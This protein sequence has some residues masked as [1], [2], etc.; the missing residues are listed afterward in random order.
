M[1]G[2]ARAVGAGTLIDWEGT[3]YVFDGLTLEDYGILK[4]HLVEKKRKDKIGFIL[5]LAGTL[6]SDVHREHLDRA[7]VEAGQIADVEDEE[8]DKWVHTPDGAATAMWLSLSKRYGI[9]KAP[10][11]ERILRKLQEDYEG[12]LRLAEINSKRDMATG[13]DKSGNSTGQGEAATLAEE[14]AASTGTS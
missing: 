8:L 5:S 12:Q 11:K 6:P 14:P 10:S 9:D 2:M 1:E 3:T 4:N 13:V 7:I